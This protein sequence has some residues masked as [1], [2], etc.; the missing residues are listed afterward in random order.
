MEKRELDP[1]SK[2]PGVFAFGLFIDSEIF[3]APS[4]VLDEVQGRKLR[5]VVIAYAASPPPMAGVR[6]S[7]INLSTSLAGTMRLREYFTVLIF[8]P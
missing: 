1:R 4:L 5:M 3:P 7:E 8:R 2:W 6:F